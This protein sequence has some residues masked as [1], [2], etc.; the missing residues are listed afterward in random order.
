MTALSCLRL[1][2][3]RL[4]LR[5]LRRVACICAVCL[6]W[7]GLTTL[8]VSATARVDYAVGVCYGAA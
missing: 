6:L 4:G 8:L 1:T 5:R 2:A 3:N 7:L